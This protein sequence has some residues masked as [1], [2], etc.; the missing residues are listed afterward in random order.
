MA[1]NDRIGKQRERDRLAALHRLEILDSGYE[2]PFDRIVG[3]VAEFFCVP[4]VGIHLLD[5]ERQWVKAFE[6]QP[7]PCAREDSV[8][9]FALSHDDLL[10]IPDLSKDSRTCGL[11]IVIRE[12]HLRFYAGMPLWTRDGYAIGTLCLIDYQPRAALDIQKTQW[13]REFA[14]LVI[15]TMDIRVKY[16]QSQ[17]GLLKAVEFDAITGLR[18]RE[19]LLRESQRRLNTMQRQGGVAVIKIRLDRTDLVMGATGQTGTN[20]ALS[21]TAQRLKVILGTD[22][23]LGRGDGGTFLLVRVS[24]G[25]SAEQQLDSWL[26]TTASEILF[27]LAQPMNIAGHRINITASVGLAAFTDDSPVEK[28]ADAAGAAS[29]FAQTNGGN[30]AQHFTDNTSIQFKE[31]AGMEAALRD[32]LTH[33]AF[34]VHYQ[35]IVDLSQ[36]GC[37]VGAE[38][39]VRWP[40][41]DKY[42]VGPDRFI[43]IAEKIGLI[44]DLGLWVFATVCRD[45]ATWLSQG[46]DIWISVNISPLQLNDPQLNSNLIECAKA[47][48]V[49]C[50]RFKLEITESALSL[51]SREVDHTFNQ[52]RE[53]GFL[54]ALDD[55]GTGHSSLAR[56]I[57]MP[58]DTIK[59]DREFVNHCPH[60]L[61]ATVV[62]S[63]S[64]LARELGMILVAEGVEHESQERFLRNSGYSLAQ[65][66]YYARPMP[67]QKLTAH[68]TAYARPLHRGTG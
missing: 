40:Q 53:A 9:Q 24:N 35:P 13:L 37:V 64:A 58:F 65:G 59:V 2:P 20:E 42:V 15:E 49:D 41:N 56:L 45:L 46:H 50:S 67:A 34:E 29:I 63:V 22:D 23:L 17:Q 43:P 47:A 68:L 5:D 32:A 10:V 3:M 36:G 57:R 33:S 48:G 8:C 66:Y 62:A 51:H 60:G 39:L 16:H 19:S 6:G 54:L 12:P 25:P 28:V 30:Q 61:G 4:N 18:N 55:F 31:R 21:V 44:H 11:D 38:A 27:R 14:D 52:L 7:F 26:D 1:G